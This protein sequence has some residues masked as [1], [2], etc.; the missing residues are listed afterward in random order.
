MNNRYFFTAAFLIV[1]LIARSAPAYLIVDFNDLT[2]DG[3][4]SYWN[5]S[6]GSGGFYSGDVFFTN[7]YEYYPAFDM[8]AWSGFAYSN[9]DR[10]GAGGHTNQYAVY[11]PGTGRSGAGNYV[12]AYYVEEGFS[13]EFRPRLSLS[14]PAEV[15]DL[16]VNNT[17]YTA[18]F[19][20]DGDIDRGFSP[21]EEGDWYRLHIQGLDEGLNPLGSEAVVYLADYRD[22]QTFIMD[23]WTPVELASVFG[24]PVQHIEF[25][26][27]GSKTG[28]WGLETPTYFALDDIRIIPEPGVLGLVLFGLAGLWIVQRRRL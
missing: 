16:Y 5:G 14:S 24:G 20:R 11:D 28:D 2:L 13:D 15:L 10:P 18:L 6:D 3:P 22:G 7:Q 12:V 26:V 9:I 1:G 27:E 23:E 25:R 19:I 4:D 17:A 21:F 8:E